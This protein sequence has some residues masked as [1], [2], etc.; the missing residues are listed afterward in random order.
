M[1]EHSSKGE[2]LEIVTL[3]NFLLKSRLGDVGCDP[4]QGNNITIQ[5]L[6]VGTGEPERSQVGG[7]Q[8]PTGGVGLVSTEPTANW[9]DHGKAAVDG[10]YQFETP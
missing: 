7:L 2:V 9:K 8:S 1:S 6:F 5:P 4:P 3:G 10:S